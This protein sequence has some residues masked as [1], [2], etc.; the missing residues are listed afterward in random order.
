MRIEKLLWPKAKLSGAVCTALLLISSLI[1]TNAQQGGTI[2]GRVVNDEGTG[3]PNLSVYLNQAPTGRRESIN[4]GNIM[5]ITD[6]DG[7]FRA[8][9]LAPSLYS[10]NIAQAKEYTMQPLTAAERREQRY[11]RTGD[12]VTITLVRGGVITG[13]VTNSD[14]QPIVGVQV[15]AMMVR[16]TEGHP[17][18]QSSG[19]GRA[20]ATDDRGIYRLF[21]LSPGT[22]LVSSNGRMMYY[23]VSPYDGNVTTYHPSSNRDSATEV[24]VTS[25]GEVTGVDIR[26]RGER[27]R[28]VSGTVTNASESPA[29][30]TNVI[31]LSTTSGIFTG[32]SNTRKDENNRMGFSING[33][34]DGEYDLIAYSGGNEGVGVA[35][36][37]PRRVT[38]NNADVSGIELRLVPYA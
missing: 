32:S 26:F 7:N 4:R 19:G 2:S 3:V 17:V 31:L 10:I 25:G 30:Y 6:E 18:R 1:L 28:F 33:V 8:A 14:G 5:V 21:G 12:N 20:R 13:K 29:T 38:V 9:G 22:Y 27:G 36:S 15:F 24:A 35:I 11:Y 23:G 16:D 34:T 37:A